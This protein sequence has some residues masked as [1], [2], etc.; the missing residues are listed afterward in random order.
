MKVGMNNHHV[1]WHWW[2]CTRS[3]VSEYPKLKCLASLPFI[4]CY[5]WKV[6]YTKLKP[7]NLW[8]RH[9]CFD[10]V[11]FRRA[12]L[13]MFILMMFMIV[14]FILILMLGS[15]VTYLNISTTFW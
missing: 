8:Q 15:F 14:M 11:A 2:K 12:W 4:A 9:V 3:E 7:V 1:S 13:V 6:N 5:G 10:G